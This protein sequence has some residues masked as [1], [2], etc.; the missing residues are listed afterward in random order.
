MQNSYLFHLEDKMSVMRKFYYGILLG[1][2]LSA[3]RPPT[4]NTSPIQLLAGNDQPLSATT[5]GSW[6]K[7]HPEKEQTLQQF[8]AASV[9][10]DTSRRTIQLLLVG[11]PDPK[12]DTLLALIAEH[13]QLYFQLPVKLLPPDSTIPPAGFTRT[14]ASGQIQW[15][16]DWLLDKVLHPLSAPG[17]AATAG[18]TSIDLYPSDSWNFVM[19]LA[20][21]HRQVS[22][23][24]WYRL[25]PPGV[26]KSISPQLLTRLLKTITHE[27]GHMLGL[28]H[29][30]HAAC[31]M[32]GSNSVSEADRQP[33]RLCS[34]CLQKLSSLHA[35][36]L[37]KRNS[38]LMQWYRHH[39]VPNLAQEL[40]ADS[41][42]L[43]SYA[44][45]FSYIGR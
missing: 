7:V 11:P 37:V 9:L 19:G 34:Q 16:A 6:R 14:G 32:N 24:S 4:P 33:L 39:R 25:Q 30:Q 42:S 2:A 15:R 27:T 29:C 28:A 10:G 44:H 18:V 20:S 31:S 43:S 26:H 1:G 23:S 13:L 5:P 35:A 8:R 21:Y 41:I 38:R 17:V 40:T 36:D 22:I 3:C 45:I 12:A